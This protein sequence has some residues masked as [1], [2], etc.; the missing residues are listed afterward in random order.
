MLSLSFLERLKKEQEHFRELE[1]KLA[2]PQLMQDSQALKQIAREHARLEG[3]AK[4]IDDYLHLFGQWQQSD[5]LVKEEKD[6]ELRLLAQEE[7]K[8]LTKQ[9][10]EQRKEIELLLIAPSPHEE[11]SLFMEIRAGTGGSE[12]ALFVSDLT[13]M[14]M[15]FTEQQGLKAEL[16]HSSPTELGGY[17]EIIFSVAGKEAYLFLHREGGTH[18]VQRIPSTESN[19]R[20][21]TSAVTVA[22]L[23]EREE[24]EVEIKDSDIKIDVFR[25]SGAGGQHV[26]KT[27]SAIRI[28]HAA[29]GIVVSCQDER[30]Q[31][32]NKARAMGILRSRLAQMQEEKA[33]LQENSLKR[34]Q[35]KS[36]DRSER[37][38]TY[39]F[40]QG[41]VTD[42]RVGYTAYN[43]EALMDGDMEELLQALIRAEREEKL[44][45]LTT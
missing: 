10:E 3:Q 21:H 42:H 12:A 40:P 32:K 33:H 24:S 44:Q 4:R 5:E 13:R 30:S 35:V 39:N 2:D 14:Y 34:E 27:E 45:A 22:V 6:K 36:G 1:E 29:S 17:K 41:R 9:L 26:N 37:I 16:V 43:L 11:R 23:P 20:I 31:H 25:A 7:A 38:R 19:G 8:E 15:R 18:R 28:T